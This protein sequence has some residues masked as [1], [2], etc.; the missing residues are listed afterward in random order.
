MHPADVVGEQNDIEVRTGTDGDRDRPR[1]PHGH[2]GRRRD[3]EYG[4]LVLATGATPRTLPGTSAIRTIDDS[5]A[6]SRRCWTTATG[7]LGVIGGGFIGVE[8]AASARMKGWDVTMA[9]PES[10]VWE[11]LFGAEVGRYFQRQLESHGVHVLHRHQGAARA[12]SYNVRAGRDRRRPQHRAGRGRRARGR[13]RR[14]GRRASVGRRR[15]LGGRRHRRVPERRARQAACGSSTGTSRST[16]AR[17]SAASGRARRTARTP[18][19]RTSSRT[20][21]TGRGSSTSGPGKGRVDIRGSMDADDFVAYY[22]TTTGAVTACLGVNRSRRRRRGQR[23][24][25]R[26]PAAAR[27]VGGRRKTVPG[28]VI[29][30]PAVSLR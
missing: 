12:G 2:A 16:R 23:A 1:R 9:V 3:L 4:R 18:S 21:A 29:H 17:T 25:H 20:S 8:A 19:C 24:D 14:A 15:H 27:R 26:A 30:L 13:Q 11:H 5:A 10:V 7:H 6:R 28:T 22:R